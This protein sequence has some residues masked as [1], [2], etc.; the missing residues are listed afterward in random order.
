MNVRQLNGF[1]EFK[2][3]CVLFFYIVKL[4]EYQKEY[5]MKN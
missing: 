2:K 4:Q 3:S 1:I 5:L